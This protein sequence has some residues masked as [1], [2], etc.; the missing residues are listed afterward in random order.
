MSK[1]GVSYQGANYTS[2]RYQL[3]YEIEIAKC[4]GDPKKLPMVTPLQDPDDP[5]VL[6]WKRSPGDIVLLECSSTDAQRWH[7]LLLEDVELDLRVQDSKTKI[8]HER[9]KTFLTPLPSHVV[10]SFIQSRRTVRNR[11]SSEEQAS[12]RAAEKELEKYEAAE[13]ARIHAGKVAGKSLSR[14]EGL[15]SQRTKTEPRETQPNAEDLA[16]E[17]QVLAAQDRLKQELREGMDKIIRGGDS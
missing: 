6:Y 3:A 7:E 5:T 10:D 16:V 13:E 2:K 1:K 8:R 15:N 14:Q 17:Q 12:A 11:V 4:L 9:K